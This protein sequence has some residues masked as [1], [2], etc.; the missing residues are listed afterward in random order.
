M[1]SKYRYIDLL[2]Q[3]FYNLC[4]KISKFFNDLLDKYFLQWQQGYRWTLSSVIIESNVIPILKEP[5]A[6]RKRPRTGSCIKWCALSCT[7]HFSSTQRKVKLYVESG[8][9]KRKVTCINWAWRIDKGWGRLNMPF[10]YPHSTQNDMIY[11]LI[12]KDLLLIYIFIIL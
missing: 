7:W 11:K 3:Y 4:I 8:K 5:L 6:W 2:F 10:A 9:S 1:F 12:P